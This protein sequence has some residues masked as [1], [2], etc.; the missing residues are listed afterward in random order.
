MATIPARLTCQ[1]SR[2]R[3]YTVH[4]HVYIGI[5]VC[6]CAYVYV[7]SQLTPGPHSLD[8]SPSGPDHFFSYRAGWVLRPPH[9]SQAPTHW[10]LAGFITPRPMT[11]RMSP[12]LSGVEGL[13][14]S[15]TPVM[16][17]GCGKPWRVVGWRPFWSL[18]FSCVT[19]AKNAAVALVPPPCSHG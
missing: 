19:D 4:V 12:V 10:A 8:V 9:R 3:V 14:P 16:G 1:S 15:G 2:M 17:Q 5:R 11:A 6:V 7:L 18:V 13:S